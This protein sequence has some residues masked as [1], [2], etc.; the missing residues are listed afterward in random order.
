MADEYGA[1]AIALRPVF[2]FQLATERLITPARHGFKTK[3]ASAA[4]KIFA[5][6]AMMNTLSQLPV[7]F[8][9]VLA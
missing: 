6:A 9:I 4:A 3:S 7:F 2:A 5:P 8:W 1:T